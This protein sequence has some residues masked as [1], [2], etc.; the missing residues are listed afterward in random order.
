MLSKNK[1]IYWTLKSVYVIFVFSVVRVQCIKNQDSVGII[2][3][4]TVSIFQDN[5]VENKIAGLKFNISWL[6][7]T[8]G[9]PPTSYR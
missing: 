5:L 8:I 3:N 7:P 9:K 4:L 6:P 2:R 1:H